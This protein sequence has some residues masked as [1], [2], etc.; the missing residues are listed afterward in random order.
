[1]RESANSIF[2]CGDS[3]KICHRAIPHWCE[4]WRQKFRQSFH[5][6]KGFIRDL[7][8][9]KNISVVPRGQTLFSKIWLTRHPCSPRLGTRDDRI[10][11]IV[12]KHA[13]GDATLHCLIVCA[14]YPLPLSQLYRQTNGLL[15][16]VASG[17][18]WRAHGKNKTS[19]IGI[20]NTPPIPE[21]PSGSDGALTWRCPQSKW[22]TPKNATTFRTTWL[23]GNNAEIACN[24]GCLVLKTFSRVSSHTWLDA[25][26]SAEP[27]RVKDGLAGVAKNC[28]LDTVL[29]TVKSHKGGFRATQLDHKHFDATCFDA[30]CFWC[31]MFFSYLPILTGS[32]LWWWRAMCCM[33]RGVW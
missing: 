18:L 27:L 22:R 19:S 17:H 32:E 1:V 9:C 31:N 25:K 15:D 10:H 4:G 21:W 29:L 28:V 8:S 12:G 5:L 23:R 11:V 2:L 3:L 26:E 33:A 24:V 16:P 14:D 20:Q 30:T 6:A 13:L 7:Q